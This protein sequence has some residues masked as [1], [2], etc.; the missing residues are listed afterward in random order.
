MDV[1]IQISYFSQGLAPALPVHAKVVSLLVERGFAEARKNHAIAG[2][3]RRGPGW[4]GQLV[5]YGKLHEVLAQGRH[6][7]PVTL[8]QLTQKPNCYAVGAL[9]GLEGEVTIV[10]GDVIASCVDRSGRPVSPGKPLEQSA[11]TIAA[12]YVPRWMETNI[13]RHVDADAL[14]PF[15]RQAAEIQADDMHGVCLRVVAR[16][17]LGNQVGR[18]DV[19]EVSGGKWDENNNIDRR[20]GSVGDDCSQQEH[21]V[22]EAAK[23]G[24]L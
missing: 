12:A 13:D 11:T 10:D 17:D 20:R 7:P 5:P 22:Q 1:K 15:I 2:A 16:L 6:Q 8:A 3:T 14:E 23:Q 9:A 4:N 21:D 19:E 18:P 24:N